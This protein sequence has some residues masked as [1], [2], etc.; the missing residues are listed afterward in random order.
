MYFN[1]SLKV[2]QLQFIDTYLRKKGY[3][4]NGYTYRKGFVVIDVKVKSKEIESIEIWHDGVSQEKQEIHSHFSTGL[5]IAENYF[6][7]I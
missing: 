5:I 3:D 4:S 6:S 1:V 2:D 7:R